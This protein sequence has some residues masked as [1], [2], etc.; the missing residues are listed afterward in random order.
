M[1]RAKRR[2]FSSAAAHGRIIFTAFEARVRKTGEDAV[3]CLEHRL[4]DFQL[5]VNTTLC[6]VA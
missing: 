3:M 2:H 6:V 1:L 5:W 4:T